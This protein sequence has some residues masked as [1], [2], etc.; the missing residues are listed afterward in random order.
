[1]R[2]HG[3]SLIYILP[4]LIGFVVPA[5]AQ[6]VS[7]PD[8]GLNAAIRDTLHKPAGPLTPED[9]L[10]LT[11]L[12]AAS[13]NVSSTAGLEGARNLVSLSLFN[14]QLTDFVLPSELRNL[15]VLD[16]GFNSLAGCS[17][18]DDMTNLNAL[19]LEGNALTDFVLPA[20]LT[21]LTK[22]DLAANA[23]GRFALRP[24]M[25]N[26]VFALIFANQLTNL[27]LPPTLHRLLGLDLNFNRFRSLTLPLGLDN[28][29]RLD[30]R[31]NQLTHLTLPA[32][33]T[34]L[35]ILDLGL[36]QL[37]EI[38]LPPNL[39]NLTSLF[40]DADPL[41]T[42]VL[43]ELLAATNLADTVALLRSQG[44]SVFTYPLTVQLIR[45]RQPLGAFQF[46]I[47]G[48]PAAYAILA[49]TNLTDWTALTT[50]TN[51]LGAIVFTDGAAH[52]SPR[53]FYRALE[54]GP[55][56]NMV[57]I[58]P[59][60]F[61]MGSPTNE[62][63]RDSNEGPQTTVTLTRGFWIG[64]YEITQGEYV[65]IMN[66]NPSFFPGDLSRAISSVSWPDATNFC[67]K[68]TERELAAGRIPPGSRYR[69]PTEAE[70][71]CAARAGTS[72][73]FSYGD[74]PNYTSLTNHAWYF[75]N[76]GLTVH[77]V[78]QKLPNPWGLYDMEGNVWEWCQDW[79]GPLPGGAVTDPQGPPS[80]PIGV[81]VIRGGAYDFADPDCRSARRF[82]YGVHPALN[83][84]DLGFR[85][86]LV[87]EP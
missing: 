15:A 6:E 32:D 62:L 13:R 81:K 17:L 25:T 36:N 39:T 3:R 82:S 75:L 86:V 70:W 10:S 44:V 51:P 63:H 52:L 4:I 85:V 77:P 73:R 46:A 72:T 58:P 83:D 23:L 18:P 79:L 65:S 67:A 28:L 1:M 66:T 26:L 54:Q 57:F 20:G 71:E 43:S 69:L 31:G 61:T 48:P 14:N 53:K 68:L 49:S 78:G 59:N 34:Q 33:M 9:L 8:P 22:L 24:E 29:N 21:A 76:A 19:F 35:S 47:T 38:T 37:T 5:G 11:N 56:T 7:I 55:P 50:V 84:T 42:F 64:K 16:L 40:I 80:N 45:I 2:E 60:I 27:S 87:T 74:D 12:V 41:N 30:L